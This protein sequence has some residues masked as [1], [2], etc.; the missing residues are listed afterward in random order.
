MQVR[1]LVV[2]VLIAALYSAMV[3]VFHPIS[4]HVIQVRIANALIGVVPILGKPAIIGITLGVLIG[5]I[6]S[7]LGVLDILSFIPTF[8]GLTIIYKLRNV[9]VLLGLLIYSLILGAWV[10]FLLWYILG[11]PY[12]ISF[13][14]VTIGIMIATSGLGYMVYMVLSKYFKVISYG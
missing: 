13:I 10:S 3:I 6:T 14:Y 7:P 1:D 11:L 8:V 9:S 12:V 5:N 2:S 4:F